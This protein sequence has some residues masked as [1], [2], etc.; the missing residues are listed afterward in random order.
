VGSGVVAEIYRY[1][2][3]L[4]ACRGDETC[5]FPYL[6]DN[7]HVTAFPNGHRRPNQA[8]I[9]FSASLASGRIL[10]R[11]GP[12]AVSW[13]GQRW[14]WIGFACCGGGPAETE[15]SFSSFQCL[16]SGVRLTFPS[17]SLM[18]PEL[19]DPSMRTQSS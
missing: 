17:G 15:D 1:R 8:K 4:I 12:T 7:G 11:C 3:I 2:V 19:W 9:E 18:I 16:G 6:R 10:E 13:A 5:R 14:P